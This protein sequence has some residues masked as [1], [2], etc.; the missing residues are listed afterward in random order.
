MLIPMLH[1]GLAGLAGCSVATL[2]P[3]QIYATA[4][5]AGFPSDVAT[6]MTAIALRESGGCPTAYYG[7]SPPGAESSYGL[8]QINVKGNPTILTRLGITA[9]Q[10]YDPATNAAAA[11]LLYGGNPNNLN[12]AWYI[13]TPG[14]YQDNY[15]AQLPVAEAAAQSV[16]SG[17]LTVAELTAA[18]LDPTLASNSSDSTDS[19]SDSSDDVLAGMSGTQLAIGAG[20]LAL[21][22]LVAFS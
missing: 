12:V 19:T 3:E 20:I 4:E 17:G 10:L 14:P 15:L 11:M 7:G 6:Q 8:W 22:G 2:T 18:G 5:A 13:N 21:L 1:I 16:D 9:D